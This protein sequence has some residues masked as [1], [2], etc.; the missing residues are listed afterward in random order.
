MKGLLIQNGAKIDA[1]D[2]ESQGVLDAAVIG[3]AD[4]NMIE[5]LS[6]KLG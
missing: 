1:R 6:G 5:Y 4:R 3:G 2:K